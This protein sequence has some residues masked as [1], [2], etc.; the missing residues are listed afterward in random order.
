MSEQDGGVGRE[1]KVSHGRKVK[2]KH[3]YSWQLRETL[4]YVHA[5]LSRDPL[6]IV[7]NLKLHNNKN[8]YQYLQLTFVAGGQLSNP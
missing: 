5:E 7:E 3:S 6:A 1:Q 4:T 8:L 2:G